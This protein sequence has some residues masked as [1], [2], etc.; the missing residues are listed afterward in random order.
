MAFGRNGHPDRRV[1]SDRALAQALGRDAAIVRRPDGKPETTAGVE[2]SVSHSGELVLAVAGPG[3]VGCDIEA[4][5]PR[6]PEVWHDL[7]GSERRSLLELVCRESGD[8]LDAAATRLWTVIESLKKSG[9][10]PGAPIVFSAVTPDG[11]VL[12]HCGHQTA[13]TVLLPAPGNTRQRLS[14][15]VLAERR[16]AGVSHCAAVL[17]EP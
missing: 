5:E 8:D 14:C 2:I 4:V 17:A 10:T 9:Q 12:F 11:W 6:A 15:A 16:D 1:R 7:L 3:P 13:V